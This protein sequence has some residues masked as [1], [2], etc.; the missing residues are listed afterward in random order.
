M[1]R[2]LASN[3]RPIAITMGDPTGIGPEVT[4]NAWLALRGGSESFCVLGDPRLYQDVPTQVVPDISEAPAVF[5]KALPIL[6]GF[7]T[8]ACMPGHP[9]AHHSKL[10]LKSIELGVELVARGEA[11]ALVTA[12]IAKSVL[13]EAG[14]THP[15]HTDYLGELTAQ[16]PFKETRG[17]I[18]MLC[19]EGLRVVPVTV[20]C[21]LAQVSA[22]LTKQSIVHAA[23]VT[24]EALKRDFGLSTPRLVIAA[25]NPHAGENGAF[26]EEESRIIAPAVQ[27]L[28]ARSI[29][30]T[31]PVPADSLFHA[32]ARVN[33]DAVICMYHDQALIPLKTLDFWGGVNV[34]LGLPIIRTSPDHGTGFDIA[35]RG[36]ARADSMIAA[37]QQGARMAN[38]RARA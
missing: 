8:K 18:M 12:P 37:I 23:L 21:A 6:A 13:L 38:W 7:T 22:R 26:G 24:H 30:V 17:P 15:G 35:G 16:M 19:V 34:T 36:I 2:P 20:H 27:E 1:H 10:I 9:H 14:F 4:A 11:K 3:T 29:N 28:M 25:L 32:D 31:G 5:D 33:Y